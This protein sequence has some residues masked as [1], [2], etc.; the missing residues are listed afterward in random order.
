LKHI[1]QNTKEIEALTNKEIFDL[2]VLKQ[3]EEG[4]V[5]N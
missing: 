3:E 1:I 2:A 5:E 4:E